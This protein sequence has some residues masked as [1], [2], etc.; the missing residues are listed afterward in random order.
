LGFFFF[1]LSN[2]CDFG[3]LAIFF[4]VSKNLVK[5]IK[6]TIEKKNFQNFRNCFCG[7]PDGICFP[8]KNTGLDGMDWR[9]W[10]W[11][12]AIWGVENLTWFEKR[13]E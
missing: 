13:G 1:F 10:V 2:F 7:K 8:E 12:R 11:G 5:L 4:C 9:V 3:N 6:F